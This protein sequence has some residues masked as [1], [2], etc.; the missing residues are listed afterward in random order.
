MHYVYILKGNRYYVW[1][2]S[3]LEKRLKKHVDWRCE[4]TKRTKP[5]EL[6]WYFEKDT[7]QEAM[8][9]EKMIKK[10]WHIDYWINHNTFVKVG[11]RID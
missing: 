3:D 4:T 5:Y 10:N 6:I 2:T 8:K 1:Y 9:L 11:R 7:K